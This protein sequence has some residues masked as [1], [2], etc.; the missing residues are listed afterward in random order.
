MNG[1]AQSKSAINTHYHV[2]YFNNI[3]LLTIKIS[4]EYK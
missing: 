3:I 4:V 2:I 1:Y